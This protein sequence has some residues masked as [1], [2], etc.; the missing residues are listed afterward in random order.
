MEI[1]GNNCLTTGDEISN[2]V[3]SSWFVDNSDRMIWRREGGRIVNVWDEYVDMLGSVR[4]F[5][6][7]GEFFN[8]SK[9]DR[10][11]IGKK[12]ISHGVCKYIYRMYGCSF[13]RTYNSVHKRDSGVRVT[14][15]DIFDALINYYGMNGMNW[16]YLFRHMRTFY[17]T[18][19][20][21]LEY[22]ANDVIRGSL[23]EYFIKNH[24]LTVSGVEI[25]TSRSDGRNRKVIGM[26][27]DGG[28]RGIDLSELIV[29]KRHAWDN[30]T[31]KYPERSDIRNYDVFLGG[32]SEDIAMPDRCPVFKNIILNYT[33]IDFNNGLKN[34]KNCSLA[35]YEGSDKEE[36]SSASIDRID[37][38]KGY[39]YDNIRV[40]SDFANSLKNCYNEYHFKCILEYFRNNQ[41]TI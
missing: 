36:W 29:D 17:T 28:G 13:E 27:W 15:D 23:Y 31:K 25:D 3:K 39:S 6:F 35:V 22:I 4:E 16:G 40:I 37:S 11:S 26:K 41:P 2:S 33:G 8:N 24:N 38:N 20:G 18:N 1:D 32:R 34:K 12:E 30:M 5:L 9:Y 7:G 21:I 10:N 14:S 19:D